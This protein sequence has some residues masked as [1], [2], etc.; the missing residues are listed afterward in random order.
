M[1]RRDAFAYSQIEVG[2]EYQYGH[3]NCHQS[4][5]WKPMFPINMARLVQQTIK[6]APVRGMMFVIEAPQAG[7]ELFCS[8]K[9]SLSILNCSME[10]LPVLFPRIEAYLT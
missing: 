9:P 6:A 8:N 3:E 1:G 4:S 5:P 2:N 10:T 7:T